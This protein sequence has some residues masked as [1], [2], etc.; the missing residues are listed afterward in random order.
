MHL[1]RI[2]IPLVVVAVLLAAYYGTECA[3]SSS[4]GNT[5]TWRR[6]SNGVFD[7]TYLYTL[8]ILPVTIL[9]LFISNAT[10]RKWFNFSIWW[11]ALSVLILAAFDTRVG[12]WMNIFPITRIGVTWLFAFAYAVISAVMFA[13]PLLR[14]R[15]K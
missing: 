10:Y 6:L 1:K 9:A 12:G 2:W 13:L 4:C 14:T 7:P 8:W 11:I 5:A 15:K 3:L